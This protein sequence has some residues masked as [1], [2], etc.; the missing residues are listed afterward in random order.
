[1]LRVDKCKR[2][3][4]RTMVL[5]SV[6]PFLFSETLSGKP[7]NERWLQGLGWLMRMAARSAQEGH[8]PSGW[9][10]VADF[11]HNLLLYH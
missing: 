11:I 5:V 6:V 9:Q 7:P 4:Y 10:I 2:L 1:M 8:R 3:V